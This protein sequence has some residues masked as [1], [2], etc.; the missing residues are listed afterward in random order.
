MPSLN[1]HPA[2]APAE[3]LQSSRARSNRA[4]RAKRSEMKW[5]L[6]SW[7]VRS[8]LDVE[9]PLETARQGAEGAFSGREERK[10]DLVVRELDRYGVTIGAL[11]ETKWFGAA[12]YRVGES[13][14]LA[15]GRPVPT[16]GEPS[17]RG[18]GVAIVLSGPA[19]QAW[20]LGG[21]QW[22]A[23]SSRLV[24]TCL[25]VG[26]GKGDHLHV[27]SCYAP[28]RAASRAQKDDFYQDLEQAL[29]AVPTDQPYILLGDLNARVGSRDGTDDPWDRVRGPHGYGETN[30][31]GKDLLNFLSTNEATVCNTWFRKKDI[32]KQTWQ[33]PK[34]RHWHCI[35]FAIMRQRDRRR[36]LDVA[37]K[38]GAECNTDHQ[39]LCVKIRMSMPCRHGKAPASRGKRFDVS[40]LA[41]KER[42][43]DE[44]HELSRREEF[45]Q[46]AA[47]KAATNWPEDGTA[48]D[49]WQVLQSA[50]LES[51]E[52]VL[53]TETRHQPDWFRDSATVL[54]P[55]LKRQHNLYTRW[56][57][58]KR[59]ADQLRFRQA[60]G[61]ARQAIRD[62]KNRWFQAKAVEAQRAR[63]GGKVVWR[64]IRDMQHGRR[65]LVPSRSVTIQDEDGNPC[66]TP[67]AQQQRW[68][69]HFTKVLN[70]Q[71]HFIMEEV[72]RARQRPLRTQL[73]RKPSMEELTNAL[74]KLKNGKAGGSSNILPEMVKAACEEE[75]FQTLLLDL[76]HTVWEERKVPQEW[77]DAIIIP[78]PKKGNLNLCDNWRGIA[79]LEVVGKAV[80]RVIQARLQIVAEEELPESQCGFREGRGCSDMIFTLRQ[81]VEK[82]IE[83]HSKQFLIFV[84][85]TKAYDSVPREALWCALQKLGVP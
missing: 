28:T 61:A 47:E 46:Q 13:V 15:A 23:W 22:K 10:V 65:G 12:E 84:D 67:K 6:G 66:I 64:C 63:F 7:N 2:G 73:E 29:T 53:G 39:L 42:S 37:V 32:H 54:E 4:L 51:A 56:L 8:M 44:Q 20:R 3:D 81:L 58:T 9:G 30:D 11:Q 36:C 77:A 34:S 59:L 38:R 69:R 17:Q 16:S 52:T 71:S 75:S 26:K 55:V 24:T 27:I 76:V 80:A 57:A 33:H 74:N 83:H 70:V 79:L 25:H 85:L 60:R 21:K 19:I 18:E 41:R 72:Q 40:K 43:T 50:L 82:T 45:Q 5:K 62:A 35:D 14:V 31:A 49:K 68:K 1:P 48:E 78:I